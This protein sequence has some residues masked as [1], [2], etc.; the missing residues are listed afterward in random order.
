MGLK[1]IHL[2]VDDGDLEE[3]LA[4]ISSLANNLALEVVSVESLPPQNHKPK[5]DKLSAQEL[6][7]QL[8]QYTFDEF[9]VER[10]LTLKE[11]HRKAEEID[12][13]ETG[14]LTP[15]FAVGLVN[16]L[17]RNV[18]PKILPAQI[19][20]AMMLVNIEAMLSEKITELTGQETE[21]WRTFGNQKLLLAKKVIYSLIKESTE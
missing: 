8:D 17:R 14:F 20:E 13:R 21:K 11:F 10:D 18:D 3:V 1:E 15:G 19:A 2:L 6:Q 9:P 7:K 5:K 4:A 12:I 16:T